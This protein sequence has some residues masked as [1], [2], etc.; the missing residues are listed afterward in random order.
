MA[1]D[2]RRR[3]LRIGKR[4]YEARRTLAERLELKGIVVGGRMPGFRRAR[5]RP[6]GPEDYIEK[7]REGKLRAP[8]IGFQFANAFAPIG[9]PA[10]YLPDDQASGGFAA[11]L[12]WRSPHVAPKKPPHCRDPRD[13]ASVQPSPVPLQPRP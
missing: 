3:G 6:D 5:R 8:V 11:T 12:V 1:V 2:E 10:G 9:V 4:L 7:V 13:G